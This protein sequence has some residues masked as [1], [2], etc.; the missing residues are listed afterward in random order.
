MSGRRGNTRSSPL[1]CKISQTLWNSVLGW[2]HCIWVLPRSI[3]E[4][5]EAWNLGNG[6]VQERIIWSCSCPTIIWIIW[7]ERN[8]RC[9]KGK[10]SNVKD[11]IDNQKFAIASW[12]SI[13]SQFYAISIDMIVNN[14]REAGSLYLGFFSASFVIV[15]R[16]F[17]GFFCIVFLSGWLVH[18]SGNVQLLLM[19]VTISKEF[20]NYQ[21]SSRIE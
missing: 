17:W 6:L 8:S 19:K 14:W 18:S 4:L 12:F 7:K 9:F 5:F 10:A 20:Q 16:N 11:L 3:F 1:C 21:T 13:L 2:F 15:F